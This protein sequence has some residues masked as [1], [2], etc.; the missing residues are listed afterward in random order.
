[1]PRC[2]ACLVSNSS[3]PSTH[4]LHKLPYCQLLQ[5]SAFR[6]WSGHECLY[7]CGVQPMTPFRDTADLSKHR[8]SHQHPRSVVKKSAWPDAGTSLLQ[9]SGANEGWGDRMG[10]IAQSPGIS[11]SCAPAKCI[12]ISGKTCLEA[13]WLPS[14][15]PARAALTIFRCRGSGARGQRQTSHLLSRAPQSCST[16]RHS[17]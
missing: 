3:L 6:A 10:S 16:R 5:L 14:D 2:A 1:M 17:I 9:D 13:Q 7:S 4:S 12:A 11:C 15:W 8:C